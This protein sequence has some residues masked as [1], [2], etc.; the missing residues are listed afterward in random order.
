MGGISLSQHSL[1]RGESESALA[2][3]ST[4]AGG[5]ANARPGTRRNYTLDNDV[6]SIGRSGQSRSQPRVVVLRGSKAEK[7]KF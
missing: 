2:D 6:F 4:A 1:A 7:A 3:L 5:R